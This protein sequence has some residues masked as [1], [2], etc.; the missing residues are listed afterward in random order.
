MSQVNSKTLAPEQYSEIQ[1]DAIRFRDVIE[2]FLRAW[3]YIQPMRW[4]ASAYVISVIFLFLWQTGTGFIIFGLIYNNVV[5]N[6]PVAAISASLLFLEPQQWVAVEE[7]SNQQRLSLIMPVLVLA[8]IATGVGEA[9]GHV[10]AYYRVW[11]MQNV[12]QALRVHIMSQM[13]LLSMNFHNNAKTGDG[14]YR[15]LQDSAMVTQIL[16]T[17]MIDPFLRVIRFLLGILVVSAFSPLLGTI[18]LFSWLPMLW[19]AKR[20]SPT[21]RRQFKQARSTSANLT[22]NIQESIEGIRT[23]K[24]NSLE[25]NRQA[26]FEKASVEAFSASHDARVT[27]LF[28]GFYIFCCTAI[29]LIVVELAAAYLAYQGADTFLRDLLL[30]F[31][32]AVWNL[33][34][35]DQARARA[36]QAAGSVEDLFT[37]WGRA[38]DMAMGL[39]RAYQVLD[40]KPAVEDLP[41][42]IPLERVAKDVEFRDVHFS[43][44]ERAL[45]DGVSFKAPAGQI[46]ALVGPTGSGKSSLMFLLLRLF[47]IDQGEIL[48]DGTEI[49]K[50][51][52]DSVRENI[53][54][55]TQENI[56][57]STTV[58]ENIRYAQPTATENEVMWAAQVAEAT[59]FIEKLPLGYQTDLGEKAARL[60]TGQRQRIVMAR[61]LLKKTPVLI[62]DE[63]TASLDV[64]TEHRI[65][66]NIK[67]QLADKTIF[68]ITHRLSTVRQADQ[69]VYLKS[70][71][72]QEHG[73][74]QELANGSG[75][76][77]RFVAAELD[78]V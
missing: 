58:M 47:E 15:L 53:T 74:Y 55:A 67:R 43:Y 75:P 13:Q 66:E 32:F 49:R 3:P 23:V 9:L 54:L 30:G 18:L 62:L 33:G 78:E 72:V 4:H 8:I 56:L 26:A 48:I 45:F 31:G 6:Q 1:A 24:V 34:G 11:I 44:P 2:L 76:F 10:I 68:L 46:T 39:N 73:T 37:L 29:P 14:I 60:S 64:V 61:A 59:Q 50:F 17:L 28:F 35:Q 16:Q 52:K 71:Q 20:L 41:D 21:L 22:S 27:L 40:L 5:L 65:L 63:P 69:I 57:F 42:A 7:I 36:R 19:V 25:G 51:T 12:N 70:G 77:S 38:Q